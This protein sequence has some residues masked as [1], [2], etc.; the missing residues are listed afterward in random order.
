MRPGSTL[1]TV[2]EPS[3]CPA[4]IFCME[5]KAVV[6]LGAQGV[7]AS[8]GGM[9]PPLVVCYVAQNIVEPS[10]CSALGYA[11]SW[12]YALASPRSYQTRQ[13]FGAHGIPLSW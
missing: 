4:P 5:S 8:A 2:A 9:V 10:T 11:C 1:Q 7:P 6:R 3:A 13:V 12:G